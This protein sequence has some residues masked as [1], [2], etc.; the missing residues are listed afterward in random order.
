[1]P[2]TWSCEVSR[3]LPR[4]RNGVLLFARYV[5]PETTRFRSA[6]VQRRIV[7]SRSVTR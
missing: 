5:L 7:P 4:E 2:S 3:R 1:M 6:V